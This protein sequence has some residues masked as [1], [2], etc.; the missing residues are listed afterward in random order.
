MTTRQ[1]I[2]KQLQED[3]LK[4]SVSNGYNTDVTNVRI[5]I[6]N[7]KSMGIKPNLGLWSYEDEVIDQIMDTDVLRNLKFLVYG[8]IDITLDDSDP[9]YKYASD[10]EKFL[11]STDNTYVDDTLYN[12]TKLNFGGVKNAG[13]FVIFFDIHYK[14]TN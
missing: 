12:L 14:Q 8:F 10:M 7:E 2:T 11:Y 6:I 13:F 3:M 1:V 9:L 4:I 5:G